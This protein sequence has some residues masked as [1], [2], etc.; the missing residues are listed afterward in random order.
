MFYQ[1]STSATCIHDLMVDWG[2]FTTRMKAKSVSVMGSVSLSKDGKS[3]VFRDMKH[4]FGHDFMR[5]WD[6]PWLGPALVKPIMPQALGHWPC[7]KPMS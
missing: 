4:A 2:L 5:R 3:Q 7:T 1:T 6:C